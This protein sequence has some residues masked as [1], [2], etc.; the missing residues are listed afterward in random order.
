MKSLRDTR[1]D[2]GLS[3]EQLS[4]MTG[5]TIANISLVENGHHKPNE[6]TRERIESVLGRIDWIETQKVTLQ[7]ANFYR[8]ERLLKRLVALSLTMCECDRE[9]LKNL[10]H[11]YF[12]KLKTEK[13]EN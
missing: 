11:K 9:E 13:D 6:F 1:K 2:Q 10:I 7:T 4:R 5:I 3:Q 8:A 12:P